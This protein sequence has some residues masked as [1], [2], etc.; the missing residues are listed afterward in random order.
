MKAIKLLCKTGG[1]AY[2][3]TPEIGKNKGQIS[4][5]DAQALV[6]AGLAV[7]MKVVVSGEAVVNAK[8]ADLEKANEVLVR[9]N[10]D[11]E[12]KIVALDGFVQEAINSAKGTIPDGYEKA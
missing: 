12:A 2:G 10:A 6:D 1:F 9:A 4:S 5:E 8:V 3:E 11:L 7:E